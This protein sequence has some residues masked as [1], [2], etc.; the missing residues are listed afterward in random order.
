MN[1]KFRVEIVSN[2]GEV[3]TV[4]GSGLSESRAERRES[5]GLSRIDTDNFF[6]RTVEEV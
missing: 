1:K 5:I 2:S 6:V 4:I 3:K